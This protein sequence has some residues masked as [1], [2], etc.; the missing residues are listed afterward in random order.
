[1]NKSSNLMFHEVLDDF[2]L[3][4]GWHIESNGK[5]TV[6]NFF[7][8]DIIKNF[9]NS[10]NYTFDDGG[11]SNISAS[12]ILERNKIIGIFFIPTFYI[13]KK[14]FM[15]MDEIKSIS[16]KHK[17]FSHGHCHLMKTFNKDLLFN[18][19]NKSLSIMKKN[20]L[21][22]DTVCLPGG[23][24]SKSHY[25][26]FKKLGIKNVYHSAPTNLI[27]NLLYGREIN[28]FPRHI[29]DRNFKSKR[30]LDYK[31]FKALIK[32]IINFFK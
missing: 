6:T 2:T 21:N 14:G 31:G 27:L 19:W 3:R 23:T 18:D 22:F 1:M 10:V 20:N 15:N 5:Y 9:G 11:V 24:F 29:V 4:S 12:K 13:G 17:I 8:N 7:F 30:Y 25:F 28:F 16:K 26:V 32:Q